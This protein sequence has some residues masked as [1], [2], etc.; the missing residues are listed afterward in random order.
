MRKAQDPG[1]IMQ[2]P[3]WEVPKFCELYPYAVDNPALWLRGQPLTAIG[4]S[5]DFSP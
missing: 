1:E 3:V 2:R 4:L 5:L